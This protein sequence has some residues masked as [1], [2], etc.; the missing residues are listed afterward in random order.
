MYSAE[1]GNKFIIYDWILIV[2]ELR[3]LYVFESLRTS[4]YYKIVCHFRNR[5]S[6][7][8]DTVY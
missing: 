4:L 7:A 8:K 5:K 6:G 3:I 1:N 2:T